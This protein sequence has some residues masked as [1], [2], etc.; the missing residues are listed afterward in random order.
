MDQFPAVN[1]FE[2]E[3]KDKIESKFKL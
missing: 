2:K 3:F 1:A